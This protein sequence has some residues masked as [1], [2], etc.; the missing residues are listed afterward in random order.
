[1][2]KNVRDYFNNVIF[3]IL[4]LISGCTFNNKSNDSYEQIEYEEIIIFNK[5]D[6][7]TE[8]YKLEEV[9]VK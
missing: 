5:L 9:K 6:G 7:N 1:M 2:K 8:L 3:F 4:I